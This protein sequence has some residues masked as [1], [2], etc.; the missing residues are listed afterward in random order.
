[1]RRKPQ[2]A[3]H[4]C[5]SRTACG[6]QQTGGS[7]TQTRRRRH[8]GTQHVPAGGR[9]YLCQARDLGERV[10]VEFEDGG[11][12]VGVCDGSPLFGHRLRG[13][14]TSGAERTTAT[15]TFAKGA[16]LKSLQNVPLQGLDR[17]GQGRNNGWATPLHIAVKARSKGRATTPARGA[18]APD[19]SVTSRHGNAVRQPTPPSIRLASS[20]SLDSPSCCSGASAALDCRAGVRHISFW[21]QAACRRRARARRRSMC[22]SCPKSILPPPPPAF[23]FM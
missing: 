6:A 14:H 5:T 11:D 21:N 13:S 18:P 16:T 3:P 23:S 15:T 17:A 2:S 10:I 7:C 1:M 22:R 4:G 12:F 8:A 19:Q 20:V 9:V